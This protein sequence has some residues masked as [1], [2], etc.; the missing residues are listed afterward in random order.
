MPARI[1]VRL[2]PAGSITPPSQT[3]PGVAAAFL[4]A[5]RDAGEGGLSAAL[6][7]ARP[8]KPYALTPLLDERDRRAGASSERVRFEVGVLADSLTAP[9]VQ[10]LAATAELR[11]ARGRYKVAGVDLAGAEPFPELLAAAEP[12][13]R[14]SLRVAT[15]AAFFT[16]REE[17]ARRIRA[18]PEPEWVFADLQRKWSAFAADV[19]L[20]ETTG[21]VIKRNL[22]VAD[23]RL[24]VAEHLVKANVPPARGSVG[25]I[26]YR[27]ADTRQAS[28]AAL[29]GLDALVRFS[30]YAGIGDRTTIGM[31]Y[32]V[33]AAR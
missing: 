28:P 20:D 13:G 30:A 5:L 21:Q 22:E 24:T 27:V 12:V 32:V 23:F 26:V 2:E 9:V 3:G 4:G 16:A 7:E 8:P 29:V 14:W 6:H 10:A 31:G 19:P 11:V 18:F 25:T 1:I 17:G 15:P 33:P